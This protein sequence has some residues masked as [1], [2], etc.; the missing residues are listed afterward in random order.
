M[1]GRLSGAWSCWSCGL[2]FALLLFGFG[3]GLGLGDFTGNLRWVVCGGLIPFGDDL[4]ARLLGV[5]WR[6][7]LGVVLVDR[8]E[9]RPAALVGDDGL[10]RVLGEHPVEHAAHVVVD[11]S[12]KGFGALVDRHEPVLELREHAVQPPRRRVALPQVSLETAREPLVLLAV[13]PARE[14]ALLPRFPAEPL[15]H[16]FKIGAKI[17][18]RGFMHPVLEQLFEPVVRRLVHKGGCVGV[19]HK[20]D[21]GSLAGL[22][23]DVDLSLLGVAVLFQRALGNLGFPHFI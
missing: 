11:R 22:N 13:Q 5:L 1:S 23:C 21:D 8:G 7:F 3:L 14:L 4:V 19:R 12:A 18:R 9:R 16:N 6:G 15:F 20:C 10:L 2:C 17:V